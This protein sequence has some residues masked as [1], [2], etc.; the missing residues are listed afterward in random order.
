[1]SVPA[2]GLT[3][4]GQIVPA[5]AISKKAPEYPKVARQVGTSGVVEIQAIIGVDG[6]VKDATVVNGNPMLQKAALDAVRE[7]KYKPAL[8][9]GKPV[10]SPVQI[11]LNFTPER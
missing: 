11:R 1:V 10:E 8:L 7:W 2:A 9:N 3:A 4:G 6:K 5:V